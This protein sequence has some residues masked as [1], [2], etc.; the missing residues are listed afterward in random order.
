MSNK[1]LQL[2]QKKNDIF[3]GTL[4]SYREKIH[5]ISAA[6]GL[7]VI[8]LQE[9]NIFRV[10]L[11]QPVTN[12]TFDNL[13][14]AD[15]SYSCT[16][17]FIQDNTGNRKVIFPENVMWSFNETAVL[18]KKPGHADV[19]TLMTFDGGETYYA[20]HALANLGK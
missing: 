9:A 18:T 17:V 7:A 19:I 3:A 14:D 2:N 4:Q 20:A 6:N 8:D 1:V 13:P 16:L 5:N 12:I 15:Y 10:T 11:R